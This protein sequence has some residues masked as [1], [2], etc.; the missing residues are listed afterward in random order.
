[1]VHYFFFVA[2]LF[3]S[4]NKLFLCFENFSYHT[5]VICRKC[6]IKLV[7][8]RHNKI[9]K[10][11]TPAQ[12]TVRHPRQPCQHKQLERSKS[13]SWRPPPETPV[14]SHSLLDAMGKQ[15]VSLRKGQE[16]VTCVCSSLHRISMRYRHNRDIASPIPRSAHSLIVF[17]NAFSLCLSLY[18]SVH[19][20]I[21]RM[22]N[23]C[24]VCVDKGARRGG[25][26]CYV[27]V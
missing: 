26:C 1:M 25:G 8:E 17:P 13:H 20:K 7:K 23:A 9:L 10:N 27:S 21:S 3:C 4:E 6:T 12:A 18:S 11:L 24:C 15:K 14:L 22:R 5:K 16:V 2:F 19:L